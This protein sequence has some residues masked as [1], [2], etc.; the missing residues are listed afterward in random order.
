MTRGRR[1]IVNELQLQLHKNRIRIQSNIP[2]LLLLLSLSSLAQFSP[3][4]LST[5]HA[6]LEGI[7]NCTKCHDIGNKISEQ[8]CLDCHKEIQT[9]ISADRGYHA[10]SDVKK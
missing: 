6:D 4:K 7:S 1:I 5:A 3:G 9:L 2:L 8:K 10:Y